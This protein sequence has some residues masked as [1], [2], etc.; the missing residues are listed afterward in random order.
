M[1]KFKAFAR[2][3]LVKPVTASKQREAPESKEK[4]EE[5]ATQVTAENVL[6]NTD[7]YPPPELEQKLQD[8]T[9]G[10]VY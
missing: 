4:A 3:V 2:D 10:S 9:M 7:L 8:E 5:P 1:D 6:Q